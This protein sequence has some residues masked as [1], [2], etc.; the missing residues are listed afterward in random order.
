ML[1]KVI[2][3]FI[4]SFPYRLEGGQW[5]MRF[6]ILFIHQTVPDVIPSFIH[7][8]IK[9]AGCPAHWP[10]PHICFHAL[11][12]I[13]GFYLD[14]KTRE[15]LFGERWWWEG[16]DQ[17]PVTKKNLITCL[18]FGND[19]Q[20]ENCPSTTPSKPPLPICPANRAACLRFGMYRIWI[21]GTEQVLNHFPLVLVI[22]HHNKHLRGIDLLL[23]HTV[24]QEEGCN[25]F[26]ALF[27]ENNY[28][29]QTFL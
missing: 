17:T 18:Q 26:L 2:R 13:A 12:V 19:I 8:H 6:H 5:Y 29:V 11:K 7:W 25:V 9:P 4:C 24:K 10:P 27:E 21:N 22:C 23:L 1:Y 3:E 14:G 16:D 20:V 28:P 15:L